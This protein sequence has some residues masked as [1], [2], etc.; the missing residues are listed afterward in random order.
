[1]AAAILPMLL[2]L[3]NQSAP[4]VAAEVFKDFSAQYMYGDSASRIP[5]TINFR[6]EYDFI[7]VGAGSGGCVMANRLSENPGWNVLLLEAGVEENL[8]L[9]VPMMAAYNTKTDYDWKYV[10]EP[11]PLACGASPGGVCSLPRGRGLGGSSLLNYMVYTRGHYRDYD[12]WAEAGNYGWS[13]EDVNQYFEKG[14]ESYI[15]PYLNPFET[16]LLSGFRQNILDSGYGELQFQLNQT[17]F[18]QSTDEAFSNYIN[19]VTGPFTVPFGVESIAFLKI[20]NSQL[21]YDYPDF[22]AIL[23]S[24]MLRKSSSAAFRLLGLDQA[25]EDIDALNN[26]DHTSLDIIVMLTRPNSRGHII[27]KSRDPLEHPKIIP[28]FLSHPDDVPYA[29]ESL[30]KAILLGESGTLANWGSKLKENFAP[31]CE[32]FSIDNDDFW[33]CFIKNYLVSSYHVAGTCKMGPDGDPT[34]V[35]NPE[36]QVHGIAG[37]RVVDASVMPKP[38]AGHPNAVVFMI[39]EKAADMVKRKWS[40]SVHTNNIRC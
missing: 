6:Y 14:E 9:S 39:G 34:A 10:F 27:L 2:A 33:D 5:D 31:G 1:M 7:V 8:L 19:D 30:K 25:L 38:M 26:D 20:E 13:Y 12:E 4:D 35:V 24:T 29:R 3:G 36:L 22:E 11:S 28:N 37:L 23:S 17:L 15:N 21:P 18:K 32:N 40:D 16:P